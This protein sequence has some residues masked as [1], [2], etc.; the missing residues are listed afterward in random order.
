MLLLFLILIGIVIFI[1]VVSFS[2]SDKPYEPLP[3]I[4]REEATAK[5]K[6]QIDISIDSS[7]KLDMT[8]EQKERYYKG[9]RE[10]EE[11]IHHSAN[12]KW[13]RSS[14][15]QKLKSDFL[16]EHS[17]IIKSYEKKTDCIPDVYN[18]KIN[19]ESRID[20]G[21]QALNALYVFRD[22]C[23]QFPGGKLYFQD[24]WEHCHNSREECF[25]A[26]TQLE[27][28]VAY[29]EE[30]KS[31]FLYRE[32]RLPT[33]RQDLIEYLSTHENVIQKNIY[34]DFGIILK[35]DIQK[36][37]RELEKDG[38]ITRIKKSGSYLLALT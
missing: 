25:S 28:H 22:Y 20:M 23:Y 24:M 14:E 27:N 13:H 2:S 8:E 4:I 38:I 19:I 15:E 17:P 34:P 33:L 29:L 30:N 36:E 21:N 6:P 18:K 10:H 32:S 5:N 7:I 16:I 9:L 31:D 3:P 11:Y 37:L 35:A 1:I 26:I 12:P